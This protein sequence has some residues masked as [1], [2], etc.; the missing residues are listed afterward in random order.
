MDPLSITVSCVTLVTAVSKVTYSLTG[1]I[2]EWRDA[3]LDLKV[4]SQELF[5]MQ[6][7]IGNLRNTFVTKESTLPSNLRE[8]ILG[9][10]KSCIQV[11]S[12]IEASLT[13]HAKSRLGK[14]GYWT[15]GGGK[16]DMAKH[17]SSLEA[18]K[19]ALEITL[20]LVSIT[21]SRDI[22]KDTTQI[23]KEMAKLRRQLPIDQSLYRHSIPHRAPKR[24]TGNINS[25]SETYQH[26]DEAYVSGSSS[27]MEKPETDI[28]TV[29]IVSRPSI[30]QV[31]RKTGYTHTNTSTPYIQ[32]TPYYHPQTNT[33]T[34]FPPTT[35]Y[36]PANIN[37]IY[38]GRY[39][40]SRSQEQNFVGFASRVVS[41]V[42]CDIWFKE[43]KWYIRDN[44]SLA[45]V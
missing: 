3:S 32:F 4:I 44:K 27:D 19:S 21:I 38:L 33:S 36:L 15:L 22:K 9:I 16:E 30:S 26:D 28:R 5:S 12:G 24:E 41:R 7:V 6:I 10:L 29:S 37:T 42:H 8:Q 23:L 18:H 20:E 43:G 40:K 34:H 17:R 35:L 31:Y 14:G 1:F 45:A 11:V 25:F 13:K 39:S 2:R